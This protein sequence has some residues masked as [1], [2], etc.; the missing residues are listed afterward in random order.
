MLSNEL[1]KILPAF[2]NTET[3]LIDD[4]SVD[5]II[6]AIQSAQKFYAKDYEKIYP[7]FVGRDPIETANNIWEFLKDNIDYVIEPDDLQTIKSPAAIIA[8]GKRSLGGN[9]CKNFALFTG[10]VLNAYRDNELKDF[11]LYFR[12]ASYNEYEETPQHVFVV[13]VINK[14]EIWVDAVLDKFNE[15]R[16]PS[17]YIDKKIKPMALVALSGMRRLG[18]DTGGGYEGG[19]DYGSDYGYDPGYDVSADTSGDGY[20]Y[21]DN[22]DGTYTELDPQ[23]N[24]TDYYNDGTLVSGNP[25]DLSYDDSTGSYSDAS[26]SQFWDNGD[27]TYYELEPNGDLT[28]Y[29]N[30]GDIINDDGSISHDNGDGTYT[31]TGVDGDVTIYNNDGSIAAQN[32]QGGRTS[33]S[34]NPAPKAPAAKPASGG[35][36]ASTGGG[37][38]SGGGTSG[39][40]GGTSSSKP[41]TTANTP[42]DPLN[43]LIKSLSS[44]LGGKTQK[45]IVN[46][47]VPA[48][49][50]NTGTY[51]LIGGAALIALILT[52]KKK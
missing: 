12:F 30:E 46:P 38:A 17:Y 26:G 23:G 6:K 20:S 9:D 11:D 18:D 13:M 40:G 42:T 28:L 32:P 34:G 19:Y 44:L 7:Y 29:T 4:Q 51:L 2:S 39:G 50:S 49:V 1:L 47:Q 22:G 25:G 35:G 16:E 41:P 31:E 10:G 3:T 21:Y 27:G 33:R 24:L 37:G 48:K 14:K 45:P 15:H 52:R 5:D 43:A 36:F 8:T